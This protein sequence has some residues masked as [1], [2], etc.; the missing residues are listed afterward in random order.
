MKGWNGL[1]RINSI[2][3]NFAGG[4]DPSNRAT[5]NAIMRQR[6]LNRPISANPTTLMRGTKRAA[7]MASGN[8]GEIHFLDGR[9]S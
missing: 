9:S 3:E 4:T 7:L 5:T 6:K 1:T 8:S 2:E